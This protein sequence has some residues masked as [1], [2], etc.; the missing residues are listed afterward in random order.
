MNLSSVE[1]GIPP[2]QYL[3]LKN[4]CFLELRLQNNNAEEPFYVLYDLC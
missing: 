4:K 1:S 3:I 2:V